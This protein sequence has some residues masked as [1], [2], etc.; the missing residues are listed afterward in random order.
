MISANTLLPAYQ[1]ADVLLSLFFIALHTILVTVYLCSFCLQRSIFG[2]VKTLL[3]T[4]GTIAF[5]V[6]HILS[7]LI[8]HMQSLKKSQ[9]ANLQ[10]LFTSSFSLIVLFQRSLKGPPCFPSSVIDNLYLTQWPT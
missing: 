8:S 1:N 3:F 5:T 9:G 7:L 4:S 2:L 10:I 6:T